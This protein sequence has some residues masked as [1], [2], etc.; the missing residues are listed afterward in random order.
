MIRRL[1]KTVG[2]TALSALNVEASGFVEALVHIIQTHSFTSRSRHSS[3]TETGNRQVL[4]STR[5]CCKCTSSEKHM[6]E[7]WVGE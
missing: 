6:E 2:Y 4:K 1:F 7:P 5:L 3:D